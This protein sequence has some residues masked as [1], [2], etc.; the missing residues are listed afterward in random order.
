MIFYEVRLNQSVEKT[1]KLFEEI[2]KQS[3]LY[4][5]WKCEVP[6]KLV[7]QGIHLDQEYWLLEVSHLDLTKKMLVRNQMSGLFTSSKISIYHDQNSGETVVALLRP[8]SLLKGNDDSV[9]LDYV[10]QLEE[11]LILVLNQLEEHKVE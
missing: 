1:I 7:E 9:L 6:T 10:H 5:L 11:S 2:C 3:K 4:V 8:T